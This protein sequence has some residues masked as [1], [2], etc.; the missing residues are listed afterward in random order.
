M[1]DKLKA[2]KAIIKN[3][4]GRFSTQIKRDEIL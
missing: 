2:V 3:V 4:M 1:M